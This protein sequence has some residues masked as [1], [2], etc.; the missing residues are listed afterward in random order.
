MWYDS[1]PFPFGILL[2]KNVIVRIQANGGIKWRTGK[3]LTYMLALVILE[4]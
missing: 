4:C 2:A 3:R 1:S